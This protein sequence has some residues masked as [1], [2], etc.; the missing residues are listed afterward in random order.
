M[1]G[2]IVVHSD[3]RLIWRGRTFR[4]ALGAAGIRRDKREGDGAT[5]VGNFPLHRVLYRADRLDRLET[6]LPVAAI[7][8]QD[9]WCDD[10]KDANYNRP[11]TRPYPASSESLWREDELY[12]VIVLLG[13][14][15]DPVVPGAGSAIF[16]HVARPDFSPTEGCVALAK[17]DLL[18]LL[19]D[20]E[21]GT[22]I[23]ILADS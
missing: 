18:E 11:V 7:Q 22:E 20:C 14:N 6:A 5:P 8:P 9:G 4:A 21:P 15:D 1:T 10:P 17:A 23:E 3:G 19:T 2:R 13:Q 12:D 16:L